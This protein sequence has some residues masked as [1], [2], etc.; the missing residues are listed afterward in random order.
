MMTNSPSLCPHLL[1]CLQAGMLKNPWRLKKPPR[2][3]R[4]FPVCICLR[5]LLLGLP[6]HMSVHKCQRVS[7]ACHRENRSAARRGLG[8][9]EALA[10]GPVF[11]LNSVGAD[12]RCEAAPRATQHQPGLGSLGSPLSSARPAGVRGD[13]GMGAA[14]GLSSELKNPKP[15]TEAG[16]GGFP[17]SQEGVDPA[18]GFGS[19]RHSKS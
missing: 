7:Q 19:A 3:L 10:S 18:A 14:P 1:P 9:S 15:S 12:A 5:C 8:V 13:A 4:A 6:S 2:S 16:S 17:N 11:L